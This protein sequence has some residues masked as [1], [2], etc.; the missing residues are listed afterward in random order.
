[1]IFV[2]EFAFDPDTGDVWDRSGKAVEL[3]PKSIEV[4]R[5]LANANRCIVSKTDLMDAVWPDVTVSE[6]SLYQC[7]AEIRRALS[8]EDHKL[9]KTV[10]RQGYKLLT[11]DG[12]D[13]TGRQ[14]AVLGIARDT[15]D[16]LGTPPAAGKLRNWRLAA[17]LVAIA[18]VFVG[19][20][21]WPQND[22]DGIDSA[23]PSLVVLPFRNMGDDARQDFFVDG[24]T[25]DLIL[26]LARLENLRVVSRNTAFAYRD[27]QMSDT[28][29]AEA[30]GVRF[31]MQGSVRRQDER[32]RVNVEIVDTLRDTHI[33]TEQYKT[34]VGDVFTVQDSLK[35]QIVEALSVHVMQGETDKL[36]A[37]QTNNLAAYELYLRGRK[38]RHQGTLRAIRLTYWTL[39]RAIELEPD[40][41]DALIALAEAYAYDFSGINHAMDWERPPTL[42]RAA[43]ERYATRARA[44]APGLAG[45][46]IALA[47]LRLGELRWQEAIEHAQAAVALEP[48]SP[49]AHILLARTLSAVGRHDEAFSAIET[50][51]RLDPEGTPE[52][53]A[54]RG[55]A[56]FGLERLDEAMR[57]L[58]AANAATD[59]SLHWSYTALA[60]SVA[61]HLG[62]PVTAFDRG[63][64][65]FRLLGADMPV[66]LFA[67]TADQRR[68]EEGLA[69]SGLAQHASAQSIR[70]TQLDGDAIRTLLFG[71]Q[72]SSSCYAALYNPTLRITKDGNMLWALRNDIS[73]TGH[74]R[75]ENDMLC[76]YFDNLDHISPSCFEI[77]KNDPLLIED[78]RESH[79]MIGAIPCFLSPKSR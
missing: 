51:G 44:L 7:I 5:E 59:I 73:L 58:A 1:M 77:R 68:L 66:P 50:A 20:T 70:G 34:T 40:F 12:V 16:P 75:V 11:T 9:L 18:A 23:P 25:E 17:A 21:V 60:V 54:V 42:T 43:A 47:R 63:T 22:S 56:L 74:A 8:D 26:D 24:I 46:D 3:R 2:G 55:M 27:R 41:S 69:K 64:A 35:E 67:R 48:Q 38:A 76:L 33:W 10:P 72:S 32:L 4:L 71:S 28:E 15:T 36:A 57:S 13:T 65:V 30:L 62:Q 14:T 6:D 61:G 29:I 49:D 45:P 52:Q 53:H 39:E 78:L 31:V 19:W 79:A 37:P